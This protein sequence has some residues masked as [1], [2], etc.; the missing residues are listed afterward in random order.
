M[1]MPLLNAETLPAQRGSARLGIELVCGASAVTTAYATSPMKLL[2][3]RARGESVWAC[4]SSFGGGF[5]AGDQ[6][7][8]DLRLGQGTRCFLST[9]AS[10]KIYRN[11]GPSPCS[12]VTHGVLE[13]NSLLVFAPDPVQ[14]FAGSNYSQHQE[15]R[16]AGGSS[17]VLLDWFSAGR[18]ARGERW[19]FS[20]FKSR[21]DV[22]IEDER[23]FLDSIFLDAADGVV[24]APHRV[25]RY[26]CFATLLLLGATLEE[27]S[28]K[29]LEE[30]AARPVERRSPL[31]YAASP[32]R[33]GVLLRLAGEGVESVGRE[34][35]HHL[36]PLA[37]LLGDD[38]WARKW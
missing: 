18:I 10:T 21:N 17:L 1:I 38:P 9:Q 7:R 22:F 15:F 16:L 27:I 12:H 29:L 28:K 36:R 8:L 5:V 13:E 26:N 19:E 35:Y 11:P 37:V 32:F 31:V 33:N 3:P 30:I 14:A 34:L 25:G 6:T 24:A 2:A 20:R 23:V 4:T